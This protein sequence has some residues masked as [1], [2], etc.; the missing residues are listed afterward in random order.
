VTGLCMITIRNTQRRYPINSAALQKNVKKL[1]IVINYPD[2]DIG[3][4]FVSEKA[5]RTYNKE[6]RHKDKTTDV[7]S[8]PFYPH[9][10]PRQRIKVKT[11]DEKNLGDI[12]ICPEY[13]FKQLSDLYDWDEKSEKE[14]RELLN[15]RIVVL[16]IHGLCHLLGYDH[17]TA[18]QYKAMRRKELQLLAKL[19]IVT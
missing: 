17:E 12:I 15:E 10:K 16:I 13:V 1:L 18:A 11:Q 3:M 2:F 7:L 19:D 9:L 5:I 14:K 4:L 6:Y 8:F